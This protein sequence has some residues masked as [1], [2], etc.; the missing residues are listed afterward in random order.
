ME[1]NK[2][3]RKVGEKS[4]L[5]FLSTHDTYFADTFDRQI[6]NTMQNNI[7]NDFPLLLNTGFIHLENEEIKV[8]KEA[9]KLT[10]SSGYNIDKNIIEN[11]LKKL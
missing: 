1:S 2:N 9:L 3:I 4:L 5:E 8:L 7:T 11:I 10:I 6:V